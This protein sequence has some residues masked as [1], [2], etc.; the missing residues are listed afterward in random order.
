MVIRVTVD[1][2]NELQRQHGVAN[3]PT[4]H[5]HTHSVMVFTIEPF[6]T[7]STHQQMMFGFQVL[8]TLYF[9]IKGQL[10]TI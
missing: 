3:T 7:Q 6:T 4:T 9:Q 5:T 10:T 2:K 8:F 1:T